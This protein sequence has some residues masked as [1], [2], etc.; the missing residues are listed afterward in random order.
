MVF[1]P[2][3]GVVV[4]LAESWLLLYVPAFAQPALTDRVVRPIGM[5]TG[6]LFVYP[7]LSQSHFRFVV[8]MLARSV[9]VP[10]GFEEVAQEPQKYDGNLANVPIEERTTLVGLTIG[11]ALDALVAADPRYAWR[12]ED[13]VLLIRPVAAWRDPT[14]V[15]HENLGPIEI[16]AQRGM[17]IVKDLY[18]QKGLPIRWSMGG[19]LGDPLQRGR[20]LNLPIS[21]THPSAT[22]LD[23]LNAI[24]KSHGQLS[25]LVEYSRGPAEFRYSCVLLITFDGRLGGIGPTVC[26]GY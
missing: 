19:T 13:G 5:E 26:S 8:A 12:E 21:V 24:T 6:S 17:D 20:D 18:E 4:A 9:R 11:R 1:S 3:I 22:M 7:G 15:L 2:S 23:V 25:W 16:K 14:H 10:V